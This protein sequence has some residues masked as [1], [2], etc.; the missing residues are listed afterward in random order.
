MRNIGRV[1]YEPLGVTECEKCSKI[2]AEPRELIRIRNKDKKGTSIWKKK[3][4]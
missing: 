3:K 1:C 2:I 4:S